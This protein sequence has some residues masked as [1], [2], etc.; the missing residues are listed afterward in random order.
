MIEVREQPSRSFAG[1]VESF[2]RGFVLTIDLWAAGRQ[3][4]SKAFVN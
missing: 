2:D 1:A 3:E 4:R